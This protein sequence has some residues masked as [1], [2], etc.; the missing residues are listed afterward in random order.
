MVEPAC[1]RRR[2][3]KDKTKRWMKRV[4]THEEKTLCIPALASK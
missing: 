3:G 4:R 2:G 1:F